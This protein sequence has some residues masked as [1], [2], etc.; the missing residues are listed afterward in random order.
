MQTRLSR[1]LLG[2]TV[3]ALAIGLLALAAL[4]SSARMQADDFCTYGRYAAHGLFGSQV[5]WYLNWSGRYS[6]TLL[7]TILHVISTRTPAI[8]PTLALAGWVAAASWA[9]GHWLTPS[10]K[11]FPPRLMIGASLPLACLALAPNLHQVLFWQTGTV[12]Y[13]VPLIGFTALVGWWLSESAKANSIRFISVGLFLGALLLSGF[14]ETFGFV[15]TVGWLIL[16]GMWLAGRGRSPVLPQVAAGVLGAAVGLAIVAAAPGNEV[17]QGLMQAPSPLAEV[18]ARSARDAFIFGA[19]LVKYHR[20]PLALA[21]VIPLAAALLPSNDESR[22]IRSAR[23]SWIVI[24]CLPLASFVLVAAAM[25]PSEYALSSYPDGRVLITA[26]FAVVACIM[27]WSVELSRVLMARPWFRA[28]RR[29]SKPLLLIGA[30]LIAALVS[31]SLLA[32]VRQMAPDLR[33][34]AASWDQRDDSIRRAAAEGIRQLEVASLAH[35]G[36]LAEVEH[37]P[38]SWINRCIAQAYGLETV[39]PK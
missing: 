18:L 15:Q 5:Y 17:R 28:G 11:A 22:G 33:S 9:A 24:T 7:N 6:A 16:G 27:L 1:S 26:A 23:W 32:E 34:F 19:T 3:A 13:L 30:L 25:F 39:T 20:P 31:G 38:D 36:G 14:S 12:T 4:G 2:L 10:G 21:F 8:L 29:Y 37:D 35:L